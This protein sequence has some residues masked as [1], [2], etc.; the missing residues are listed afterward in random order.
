VIGTPRLVRVALAT[1]LLLVVAAA[2]V[3][4]QDAAGSDATAKRPWGQIMDYRIGPSDVLTIR[5][6]GQDDLTQTVTVRPD[7]KLSFALVGDVTAAG[8]TPVELQGEMEKALGKFVNIIPGE[9]TVIVDSVHS[10]KVSVLGEVREPGR[11]EFH[12]RVSVLDALA[13]AGGLTEFAASSKIVIFRTYLGE[14][15]K[16]EFDFDRLVKE[17]GTSAWVPVLPGDVI[18]VP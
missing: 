18:L 7:G 13:Q 16:L 17:Q 9:V 10:Y 15:E 3:H 5:V 4:G 11:F 12:S 2:P 6:R 14:D 1:V 8:L